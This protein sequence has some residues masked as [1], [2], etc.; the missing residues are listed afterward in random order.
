MDNRIGYCPQTDALDPLLTV[1]E[2][3]HCYGKLKGIPAHA[4]DTV[5]QLSSQVKRTWC[6]TKILT[7]DQ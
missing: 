1:S 7:S 3:L 2:I 5:S 6:K 4:L